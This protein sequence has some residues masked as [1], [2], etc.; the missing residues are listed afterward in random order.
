VGSVFRASLRH[1]TNHADAAKPVSIL[2]VL[3]ATPLAVDDGA[4]LDEDGNIPPARI[5]PRP[6]QTIRDLGVGPR[7]APPEEGA[8]LAQGENLDLEKAV[9]VRKAARSEAKRAKRTA[10]MERCRLPGVDGRGP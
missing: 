1:D 2:M 9:R 8:P 4:R 3:E 5:L 7:T 10:F 6:E